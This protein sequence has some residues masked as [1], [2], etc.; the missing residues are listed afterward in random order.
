MMRPSRSR[1]ALAVV[2]TLAL[3]TTLTLGVG[4]ATA[5]G[6]QPADNARLVTDEVTISQAV[7]GGSSLLDGSNPARLAEVAPAR[8]G[9]SVLNQASTTI[10]K[11]I[12]SIGGVAVNP[13][14]MNATIPTGSAVVFT[15]QV[16][17]LTGSTTLRDYLSRN[18][19]F[20]SSTGTSSPC[21]PAPAASQ[22]PVVFFPTTLNPVINVPDGVSSN[23][24]VL[25]CPISGSGPGGSGNVT[26]TMNVT[27]TST[28]PNPPT[29][30]AANIACLKP[31]DASTG[32]CSL[33]VQASFIQGAVTNTPTVTITPTT[34]ATATPTRTVTPTVASTQVIA[35]VEA[36]ITPVPI[37]PCA[38]V[39]GQQCPVTGTIQGSFGIDNGGMTWT[40]L[41]PAGLVPTGTIATVL[42]PTTVN[43]FG[44]VLLGSAPAQACPAAPSTALVCTGVTTGIGLSGGTI[45]VILPSGAVVATGVIQPAPPLPGAPPVIFPGAQGIAAIPRVS[46][47]AVPAPPVQFIPPAPAPLLPPIGP[48]PPLQGGQPPPVSR[49][50]YPEVPVIPAADTLP[51][52]FGGLALVGGFAALRGWRTS[53][54]RPD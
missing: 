24:T 15:I 13:P 32:Q 49:P 47:P 33:L 35:T 29:D 27:A 18:F 1:P 38:T 36:T 34:A 11:T 54:R 40:I 46:I 20:V 42:I 41:V 44:E 45:L 52:I 14:A 9:F 28:V 37:V 5:S 43:P 26:V 50:V 21:V 51:L 19:T 4:A 25:D 48:I 10:T 31:T 8:F 2:L 6:A 23:A 16:N 53:R 39:I 7:V 12:T 22:P 17:G 30:N 3:L